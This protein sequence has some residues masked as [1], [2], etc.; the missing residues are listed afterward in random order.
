VYPVAHDA[1]TRLTTLHRRLDVVATYSSPE[2]LAVT[3]VTPSVARCAA[4]ESPQVTLTV[5]NV[6][7]SPVQFTVA[8][9][10]RGTDGEL[11]ATRTAGPFDVAA[12]TEAPFALAGPPA[13]SEGPYR[14]ELGVMAA[15][16]RVGEPV[17]VAVQV[18][19]GVIAALDVPA[20]VYAG[21]TAPV[22]VTY[23]NTSAAPVDAAFTLEVR[24]LGGEPLVILGPQVGQV[25]AGDRLTVVFQW[26][27]GAE[28]AGSVQVAATVTP[29]QGTPRRFARPVEV[30]RPV[31][32]HR[33]L[34][35]GL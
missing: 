12:W 4:G 17:A 13:Q 6:T 10:L 14:L 15:G 18:S 8:C 28:E 20:A 23:A 11:A 5:A 30:K 35:G 9:Q 27:V 25:P 16:G 2:P 19:D 26:A 24:S 3:E 29:G 21:T 33:R 22:S 7:A 1:A 34:G 32:L 31:R